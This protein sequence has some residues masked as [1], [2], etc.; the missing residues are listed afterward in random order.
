[1]RKAWMLMLMLTATTA[2]A[3]ERMES[4]PAEWRRHV[5]AL[6]VGGLLQRTVGASMESAVSERAS[7]RLGLRVG[8]EAQWTHH[9]F[10]SGDD[11]WSSRNVTL[12]LEPGARFFLTGRAPEGIWVGPQLGLLHGW[13]HLS[14]EE[15]RFA[16]PSRTLDSRSLVASGSALAGYSAVLSGGVSLQAAAGLALSYWRPLGAPAPQPG[17]DS[18]SSTQWG[19]EPVT[20][21]SLGYAF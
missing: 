12:A 16:P 8:L 14:I 7:L 6:D 11:R 1:M 4:E 9:E 2:V 18:P 21:L 5:V 15:F 3:D 20:Q 19:L 10:S 17:V 13:S